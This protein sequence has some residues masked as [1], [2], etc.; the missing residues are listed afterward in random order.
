MNILIPVSLGELVDKITILEIK[1]SNIQDQK[2]IENI[3]KELTFLKNVLKSLDIDNQI[4]N[5]YLDL[6]KVNLKL[7]NL[8]DRIRYLEK[9]FIFDNNFVEVSKEI[10]KTN[11]IRSQIKK[12]VNLEFNSDIIEE[13]SYER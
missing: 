11:D 6:Y 7:W 1:F 9:N 4:K 3:N 10:F 13:K 8:E 12:Q 5:Y 2:K